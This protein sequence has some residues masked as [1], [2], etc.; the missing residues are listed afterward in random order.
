MKFVSIAHDLPLD[1]T[2]RKISSPIKKQMPNN[3]ASKNFDKGTEGADSSMT[4]TTITMFALNM[5]FAG[6]V[7][8]IIGTIMGLQVVIHMALFML[9]FPGNMGNFISKLKPIASF[10]VVK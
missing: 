6:A 5:V 8:E 7:K 2:S 1:K 3:D 9:P 10:N 4:F